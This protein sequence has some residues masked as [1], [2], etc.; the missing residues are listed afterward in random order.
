M[1]NNFD[2]FNFKENPYSLILGD[3][4]GTSQTMGQP[5]QQGMPQEAPQ[6]MGGEQMSQQAPQ[7]T[8]QPTGQPT[9]QPQ[10]GGEMMEE[11]ENQFA[12]GQNPDKGK[13]L[14]GAIQALEN[15]ITSSD[16]RDEILTARAIIGLLTKLMA[17]DQEKM[18]NQ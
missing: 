12:K 17:K 1:P 9:G 15:Y 10:A 16:D 2:S 14:M 7:Q 4:V 8:Q 3:A 18:M 5:A 6:E 13:P 11:E